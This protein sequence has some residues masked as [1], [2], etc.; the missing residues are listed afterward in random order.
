MDASNVAP[1]AADPRR[2]A[3]GHLRRLGRHQ[4]ASVVAT[5]IDFATMTVA[6]ELANQPPA[7]AAFVGAVVGG[8]ANF[9]MGRHFTFAA[10]HHKVAPQALRY[11]V[12][13]GASA[14]L[15]ALGELLATTVLGVQYL[16]A[17]LVV[18]VIVSVAWNY[19]MQ[20]RFVF[21]AAEVET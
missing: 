21:R 7:V 4:V 13:S 5:A 15:N 1:T 10:S 6:V 9:Q 14:T 3:A 8:L 19:P 17:R 2:G 20:H 18:A 11:A 16:L 12:V